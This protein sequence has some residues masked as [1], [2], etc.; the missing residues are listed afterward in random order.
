MNEGL[1]AC[2]LFLFFISENSLQSD[3]VKL[4]WQ[5]AFL[6]SAK[7]QMRLVPVKID[8]CFM[9]PIIAQNLYIDLYGN[10]L[11]VAL[12][13]ILDV[14]QGEIL[15]PQARKNFLIFGLTCTRKKRPQLS[16][17]TQSAIVS[18]FPISCFWLITSPES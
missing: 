14:S 16:S 3:M 12:R 17:V 4:E 2:K 15:F 10:G 5:N 7:E 8:D 11:E 13:P 1:A 9:P 6:K 18:Q